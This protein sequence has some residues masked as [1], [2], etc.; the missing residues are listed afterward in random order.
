MKGDTAIAVANIVR[1]PA[2]LNHQSAKATLLN[3]ILATRANR[4][5]ANA[6]A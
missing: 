1:L 6:V 4:N 2:G 3:G 5:K